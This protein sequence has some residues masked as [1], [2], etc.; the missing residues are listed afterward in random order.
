MTIRYHCLRND[1]FG[2]YR[3]LLHIIRI[4]ETNYGYELVSSE[5]DSNLKDNKRYHLHN[6]SIIGLPEIVE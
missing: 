4:S 2:E 3:N 1:G 5:L 6:S